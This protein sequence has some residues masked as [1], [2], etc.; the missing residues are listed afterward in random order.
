MTDQPATFPL[1]VRPVL[2]A[3]GL[4]TSEF[5]AAAADIFPGSIDIARLNG[6]YA[7]K[8]DERVSR[9]VESDSHT[10]GGEATSN[11]EDNQRDWCDIS[12]ETG[13]E[14]EH[15]L[16]ERWSQAKENGISAIGQVLLQMFLHQH[17]E[18]V[19]VRYGDGAPARV[20]RLELRILEGGH[21]IHARLRL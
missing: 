13:D 16:S 15:S 21:P 5:L 8:G 6:T 20:R 9:V 14:W 4:N 19:R 3:L 7:E 12:D 2:E 18:V 17:R 1:L 10:D 11:L